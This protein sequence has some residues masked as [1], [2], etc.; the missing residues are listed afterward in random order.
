MD[1]F[2]WYIFQLYPKFGNFSQFLFP[3][4]YN[5]GHAFGLGS[6]SFQTVYMNTSYFFNNMPK[7]RFL[8]V[9]MT[10]SCPLVRREVCRSVGSKQAPSLRLGCLWSDSH[11]APPNTEVANTRKD[12]CTAVHLVLFGLTMVLIQMCE[13]LKQCKMLSSNTEASLQISRN[14]W[15]IGLTNKSPEHAVSATCMCGKYLCVN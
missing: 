1:L 8:L 14:L 2:V 11:M 5:K 12:N 4:V 3:G 6:C 7:T 10:Q 13:I 15:E 9:S